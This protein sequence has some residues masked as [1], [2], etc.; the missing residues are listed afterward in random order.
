MQ[1]LNW[2]ASQLAWEQRLFELRNGRPVP[3]VHRTT[4]SKAA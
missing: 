3:S 2:L 1:A 4:E